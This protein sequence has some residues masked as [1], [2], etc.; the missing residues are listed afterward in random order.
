MAPRGLT[1]RG[2]ASPSQK[3]RF[4]WPI[5]GR[6]TSDVWEREV[7][8]ESKW[9][10]G[11][12]PQYRPERRGLRADRSPM[13]ASPLLKLLDQ[14]TERLRGGDVPRIFQIRAT[15]ACGSRV[16][17]IKNS[18]WL[19]RGRGE[20]ADTQPRRVGPNLL[21]L[22][23]LTGPNGRGTVRLNSHS[24]Q[25]S[26]RKHEELLRPDV[27]VERDCR[28]LSPNQTRTHVNTSQREV[29]RL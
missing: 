28:I 3:V 6:A 15:R 26:P 25:F 8:R 18:P 2:R 1:F 13:A 23:L 19:L 7:G 14:V 4:G 22:V 21:W 20:R 17:L 29:S 11:F 10:A 5:W 9:L 24:S 12:G 16:A 27:S